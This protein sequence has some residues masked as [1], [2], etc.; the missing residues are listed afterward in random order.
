MTCR[1]RLS[2]YMLHVFHCCSIVPF[3]G[4]ATSCH[5]GS[6]LSK[7]MSLHI[8]IVSCFTSSYVDF[9]HMRNEK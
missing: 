1:G 5:H 2:N 6:E 4:G 3:S 8:V 9:S 7:A